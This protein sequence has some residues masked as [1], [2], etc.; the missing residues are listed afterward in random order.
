VLAKLDEATQTGQFNERFRI[1][2]T[3][4]EVRWVHVRGFPVRNTAGKIFRLVGTAQEITEQKQAEEQVAK[5]LAIAEA[6]RAEAEA[7]RRATLA[8]T[9]DLRMDF[10]MEALLRSLEELIPYTCARVLVPEGG[11]HVL[12]L[13]ERQIPELPKTL[14]KYHPGYPLTLTADESPFL[15]RILEDRKSLLISDTKHEKEWQTFKGHSHLR[16]WLSVPLL[17]SDEYLG[18]LS[19][20]HS[21]PNCYT[22]DHLRRAEL[23]AIPAAAAIQ[24]ARLFARADVYASELEKRMVDLRQA[25]TALALAQGDRQVSEDKFQK[26]FRSSPIPFSIT[27]LKE[28]QFVDVNAAFERRY[29]YSR[30]EV[31]GRTVDELRIWE[32]PGD[33]MFM[34]EQLHRGRPI[35]N[36]I[37]RLRTK[38][39]EVKLTAYSADRI[40]FDGQ[41]CILAV[42]EDLPEYD[43]ERAN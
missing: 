38:S 29:G 8:L 27:T 4:G 32:E 18:L 36:V 43:R 12:A 6:A 24:N 21:E 3:H 28:G 37:T 5:N 19:I 40:Q 9:Q 2:C 26:V 17:A 33:R 16:S 23:L 25:E 42:S 39:G 41:P 14:P 7:L 35:R 1:V 22:K 13:G 30:E 10:V 11:P 34:I 15:K 20:G 31:V